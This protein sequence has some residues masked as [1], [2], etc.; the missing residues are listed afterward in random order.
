MAHPMTA[1]QHPA[2]GL[3]GRARGIIVLVAAVA[4]GFLLLLK[5][6]DGGS[7][8]DKVSSGGKTTIDTSGLADESTTT[9]T[10]TTLPQTGRD[11]SE[12]TVI[13]LNGS[14]KSGVA[15]ANSA[16]VGTGGFTMKDPT[17]A[18]AI[19]ATT[20]IYYDVGY[21]AEG[22]K[23]ADLLGKSTDSVKPLA[24]A[25]LGGADDGANVVVVLGTD[26]PAA[27]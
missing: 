26:T 1:P 14:G 21:Q 17:N 24:D 5:G 9:S 20:T 27:N 4:V 3:D 7:S 13:V 23:V 15:K 10:S 2:G 6:G 19:V 8:A 12:V 22:I 11:P 18:P 16:T 25:S